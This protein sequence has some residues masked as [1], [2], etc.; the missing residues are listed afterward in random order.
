MILPKEIFLAAIK[1]REDYKKTY[2]SEHEKEKLR[3]GGA[4]PL[5]NWALSDSKY[6]STHIERSMFWQEVL[7]QNNFGLFFEKFPKIQ[8][9]QIGEQLFNI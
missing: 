9:I 4:R 3:L 6:G 1:E 5:F 7:T 2:Y 8:T